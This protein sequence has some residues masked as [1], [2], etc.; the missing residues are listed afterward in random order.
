[1]QCTKCLADN[2]SESDFDTNNKGSKYSYCKA[3]RRDQRNLARR[4]RFQKPENKLKRSLVVKQK[5]QDPAKRANIIAIDSK[6]SDKKFSREYDLTVD[7]IRELISQPCSYCEETELQMT[8][9]R[10]DNAIGH[11]ESNVVPACIRC[12]L[13]RKAMPHSAWMCLVP[14]LK[15][16]RKKKLFG[17]WTGK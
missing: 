16:A 15:E 4:K 14:G 3:C 10:I 11:T 17:D 8:I 1:M 5:R 12:N 6:A 9:D 7:K 2:L 13:I